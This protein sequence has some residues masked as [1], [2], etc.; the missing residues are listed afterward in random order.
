MAGDSPSGAP[1]PVRVEALGTFR[2]L[3]GG[4]PITDAA[5]PSRRSAE[6]VQLLALSDRHRLTREQVIEALWPHLAPDAG[7]ANLRKAAHHARQALGH[8]DAVVLSGGRVELFPGRAVETDVE[9]FEQ[10]AE[11]ALRASDNAASAEAVEGYGGSLLPDSLYEEWTQVPR[12]R[13]RSLYAA[14]LRQAERWERLVEVEP[15]DEPAH[16]ELMRAALAQGNRHAAI[17]WYGR[18]RTNLERELGLP[19]GPASETLYEE[20]LEGLD[21]S[22]TAFVGRQVELARASVA[23]RA[24]EKGELGVLALRGPGGIGKSA[25]CRQVAASAR[26]QGWL[27]VPVQASLVTSPYGPL[28]NAVEHLLSRD[29]TLLDAVGEDARTTLAE[30]TP[31]AASPHR[32]PIG[33][34][35]HKVI[36][37]FRR[38]ASACRG[39]QGVLLI[40]D[41]VHLADDATVDAC[42]HL[43]RAAGGLPLLTVLAYRPDSARPI[44]TAAVAALDRAGRSLEIDLGP[45]ANEEVVALAEAG[46]QAKPDASALTR[47][48]QMANGNPF[49]ALELARGV[50]PDGSLLVAPSVWASVAARF[51]EVDD[52]TAAML[53]TLAVA[54]DDLD[55]VDVSALTGLPEPEAFA[56][57]DTALETGTLVVSGARYRF[58]HEFVRQALLEQVPPHLRITIHRETAGRLAASGAAPALIARHWLDGRRPDEA[59]PWLLAAAEHALSLA[60]FAD[61]LVH[62]DRLLQHEPEHVRASAL[63]AEALDAIGDRGAPA[64][65][66]AA[67]AVAG[68]PGSHDLRAKQGLAE[69]KQGDP[70]GALRTLE[71]IEPVT[72]AGRLAHALALSGAA[73]LGF[74]DPALGTAK[75]AESRR[76]ALQTGDNATLVIASWA[77]A[78]AAHARGD[79][80][81]SVRADLFE[82]SALP[83]LAINVFDGH[84]CISQRFL[85]GDRPYP[86][87][88]AFADSLAAEA[89]R[90]GAARGHAFAVTL[91]GEAE[92]MS[93]LLD[94]ADADLRRAAGLNRAIGAGVGEALALERRAEVEIYRGRG[95]AA[96]ALLDEALAVARD[97]DVGFHLFDRIYGARITASLDPAAALIALEEAEAGVRGPLETC[98]GCR[99]T[100]VVP[101]GIAAARGGDVDRATEYLTGAEYL[102]AVVMRLPGWDAA[103]EE[104][105]GHVAVATTRDAHAG[106]A[107]FR[108]AAEGFR[109]TG[110]V[111]DEARCTALLAGGA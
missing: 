84:L 78:A 108:A 40:I 17:R 89:E 75:A 111:L 88:I 3:V 18:L 48:L 1:G 70:A 26:A 61:A 68:E 105:K 77:Q 93:G 6:L 80:A 74:A 90:V 24:G 85:Y 4:R 49:F 76:L 15:A 91:R 25:L 110:Q 41:D 34:T 86:T 95:S 67:A 27:V 23:L 82:T 59:A 63:R 5:W 57:L 65:Y 101:A 10:R 37:A 56:L 81:G 20:C 33:L 106:A 36:G 94:E 42:A 44:L 72:V 35:R 55:P 11:A 92:L 96:L 99:I 51:L 9:R 43:G 8:E 71:G 104:L 102:A 100:L 28:V 64:A 39:V 21:K 109:V 38:L 47:I 2:V 46:A 98:P 53:R 29:R 14:L 73:V 79:L 12:D 103:V 32:S 62:L 66:A 69:I 97:S 22:A 7:A 50:V 60:A 16:R 52:D 19:P 13:L 58:R 87:V 31:L 45:L 30:L 107:H 83:E 54:G